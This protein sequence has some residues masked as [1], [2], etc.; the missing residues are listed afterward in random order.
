MRSSMVCGTAGTNHRKLDRNRYR[1]RRR[2][3]VRALYGMI[4]AK[5][6]AVT[7]VSSQYRCRAKESKMTIPN[8]VLW[9]TCELIKL[10]RLRPAKRKGYCD[11][12]RIPGEEEKDTAT[13][14]ESVSAQPP[15]PCSRISPRSSGFL[16]KEAWV[17]GQTG[18]C[19]VSEMIAV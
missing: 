6:T 2:G 9:L 3:R 18:K 14:K 7:K 11:R 13:I 1:S 15:Q 19:W 17:E 8:R 12:R 4:E 5:P 16:A 10:F